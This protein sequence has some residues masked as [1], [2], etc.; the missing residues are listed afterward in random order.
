[1]SSYAY[2]LPGKPHSPRRISTAAT[3]ATTAEIVL[4]W[5]ALTDTGGVPLT[6]YKLYSIHVD[7]AVTTLVYDGTDK[8]ETLQTTVSGLTI[9]NDYE[10]YITGMNHVDTEGT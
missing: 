5:Y 2:S 8:P 7:T 10:F 6:G 9:D 3:D 1:M 4:A